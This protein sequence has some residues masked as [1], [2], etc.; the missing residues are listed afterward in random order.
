MLNLSKYIDHTNLKADASITEIE[1]LCNE[2]VE[3]NF[4]SVCI[5]PSYVRLASKLLEKSEVKVCTVVGFPFGNTFSDVKILETER[6]IAAG[7]EEI[8]MVI[9]ISE[10]INGNYHKVEQDILDVLDV[11]RKFRCKLKVIVETA[12]LSRFQKIKACEIV[13]SAG[14]DYIKTSTGYSSAGATLEDIKLMKEYV[15]ENVKIKASG[16]IKTREFAEQLV[17][18]GATRLGTSSGVNLLK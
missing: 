13:S 18:A 11:T 17:E 15:S 16:G 14:A 2:A 3:Y 4:A 10:M 9:Q 6:S 8:D 7:A 1:K 12:V 5:M